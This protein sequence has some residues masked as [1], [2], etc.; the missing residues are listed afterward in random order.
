MRVILACPL[1]YYALIISN[2]CTAR[3]CIPLVNSSDDSYI[4]HEK[5][6]FK[7]CIDYARHDRCKLIYYYHNICQP[8]YEEDM[9]PPAK[10][11]HV[12]I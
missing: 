10:E 9:P 3:L 11:W 2:L 8:E 7:R 4:V 12:L 6:S 1:L 5:K